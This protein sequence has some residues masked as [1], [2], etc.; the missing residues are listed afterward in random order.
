MVSSVIAITGFSLKSEAGSAI[1][2]LPATD[3]GPV[4]ESRPDTDSGSVIVPDQGSIAENVILE[5]YISSEKCGEHQ[6]FSNTNTLKYTGSW[7]N[8]QKSGYEYRDI[9]PEENLPTFKTVQNKLTMT[10]FKIARKGKVIDYTGTVTVKI[11]DRKRITVTFNPAIGKLQNFMY[12]SQNNT[13][14]YPSAQ[15]F[16][17]F[18]NTSGRLLFSVLNANGTAITIKNINLNS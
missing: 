13:I 14:F 6:P 11:F 3:S 9:E 1:E 10:N 12:L 5:P 16:K 17:V 15:T 8:C 2:S 18:L 4:I 7:G